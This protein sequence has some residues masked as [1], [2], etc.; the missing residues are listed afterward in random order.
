MNI[1]ENTTLKATLYSKELVYF[2][3]FS[4]DLSARKRVS[5]DNAVRYYDTVLFGETGSESNDLKKNALSTPGLNA[6]IL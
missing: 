4:F 5:P 1:C 6:S 3:K 2:A